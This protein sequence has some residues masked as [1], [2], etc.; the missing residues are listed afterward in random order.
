MFF[1][2]NSFKS[3]LR[4]VVSAAS[5]LAFL[6]SCSAVMAPSEHSLIKPGELAPGEKPASI[7]VVVNSAIHIAEIDGV[8]G[9]NESQIEGFPKVYNNTFTQATSVSVKPGRHRL[10]V[11]CIYHQGWQGNL[12]K[13]RIREIA[14]TLEPGEDVYLYSPEQL[15][16]KETGRTLQETSNCPVLVKSSLGREAVLSDSGR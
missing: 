2:L 7:N 1:R 5:A 4:L 15:K 6:T 9:P 13:H 14:L 3:Q 10:R 8:P 12:N 16:A 11:F